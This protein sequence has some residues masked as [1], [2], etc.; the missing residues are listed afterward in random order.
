MKINCLSC[1]HN[2]DLDEA[3]ADHY[4]G[5]IK[6]YVCNAVLEIRTEQSS[7]R[8]VRIAGSPARAGIG[9]DEARNQSA[10]CEGGAGVKSRTYKAREA[11]NSGTPALS[12][13]GL[14]HAAPASHRAA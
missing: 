1:G 10:P 12:E 7:V 5:E 9:T 14:Q 2:I 11:G 4:E 3:Y 6:C 8:G 13:G